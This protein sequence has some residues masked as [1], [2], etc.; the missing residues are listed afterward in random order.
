LRGA[1]SPRWGLSGGELDL[2]LIL[3]RRGFIPRKRIELR[4]SEHKTKAQDQSFSAKYNLEKL[5]YFEETGDI[6]DAIAREKEIKGWK[7]E[8][9]IRLIESINPD[10]MDLLKA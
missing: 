7:R 9:K 2:P 1:T 4:I 10:W 6:T 3:A 5:V 8:R